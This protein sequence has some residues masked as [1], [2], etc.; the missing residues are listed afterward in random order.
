MI[1]NDSS[2][3]N[4]TMVPTKETSSSNHNVFVMQLYT[5]LTIR[6]ISAEQRIAPMVKQLRWVAQTVPVARPVR[7]S[8]RQEHIAVL[9]P[10]TSIR[11]TCICTAVN[12]PHCVDEYLNTLFRR[13]CLFLIPDPFNEEVTFEQ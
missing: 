13:D 6:Q 12:G 1:L 3:I 5:Q 4:A 10:G 11:H 7:S 2:I 8:P 9:Q